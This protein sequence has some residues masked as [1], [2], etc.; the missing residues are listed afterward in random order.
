MA[1]SFTGHNCYQRERGKLAN[2]IEVFRECAAI[3]IVYGW[4]KF[5]YMRVRTV[6]IVDLLLRRN[7]CS[8]D[9]SWRM[10]SANLGHYHRYL[11]YQTSIRQSPLVVRSD[12]DCRLSTSYAV[13]TKLP[14]AYTPDSFYWNHLR[15]QREIFRF[16]NGLAVCILH[17]SQ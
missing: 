10:F 11:L 8:L 9:I 12:F 15:N 4:L 17:I 3:L 2:E 16:A 7:R 14:N 13:Q 5:G 6:K 1:S